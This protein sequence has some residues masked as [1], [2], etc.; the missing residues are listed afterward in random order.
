M[1]VE[2]A[3]RVIHQAWRFAGPLLERAMAHHPFMDA[4]DIR[5]IIERDQATLVLVLDE[6]KVR[7]ALVLEVVQYPRC[8]VA[9]LIAVAGEFGSLRKYSEEVESFL[10]TWSRDRGCDKLGALA[11]RGWAR[12]F[13]ANAWQSRPYIAAWKSL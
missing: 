4:D 1:I 3:P 9:N 8:R 5:V 6:A 12:H 13:A 7:G 10:R 2:I 11:R